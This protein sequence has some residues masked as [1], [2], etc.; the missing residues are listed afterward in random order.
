[1]ADL[2]AIVDQEY[3]QYK[4]SD[5]VQVGKDLIKGYYG[6]P[7]VFPAPDIDVLAFT[8]INNKYSDLVTLSASNA[9]LDIDNRKDNYKDFWLPAVDKIRIKVNIQSGGSKTKVDLSGF[10]STKIVAE[11]SVLGEKMILDANGG[12]SCSQLIN[13]ESKTK[14]KVKTYTVIGVPASGTTVKKID[15]AVYIE[16]APS[17]TPQTIIVMPT[18]K[19]KGK[20]RGNKSGDAMKLTILSTNPAGNSPLSNDANVIVP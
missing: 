6:N 20:I 9:T 4:P 7:L 13:Y 10:H 18:N 5:Q 16:V 15:E 11:N 1:M 14:S 12:V 3:K 19:K 17:L 8:T 2:N